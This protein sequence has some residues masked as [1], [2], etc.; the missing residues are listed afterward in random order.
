VADVVPKRVAEHVLAPALR[1][2]GQVRLICRE[3]KP[4]RLLADL[5]LHELDVILTDAPASPQVKIRAFSHLLGSSE[6]AFFGLPEL[7]S[8]YRQNFPASLNGAPVLLPTENTVM[9]R[10]LEQWF[11][12]RNI[13]PE[14][15]GEF[16]DSALLSVFGFRGAGLFPASSVIARE[17]AAQYR[18][19]PVGK[20]SGI[21]ERLYAIT[22]ERRIK[23]PTVAAICEAAERWF[24][25]Q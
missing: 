20:V 10:S 5:A 16:E 1:L 19:R 6:I 9:R 15:I 24:K 23:H 2:S 18:V 17:L 12:A 7:T 8:K 21:S 11:E 4:D 25:P 14:I 3:D 13:R 22:V